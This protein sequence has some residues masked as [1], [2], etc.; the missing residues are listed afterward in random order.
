MNRCAKPSGVKNLASRVSRNIALL[1]S[2]QKPYT[3]G[4]S[5]SAQLGSSSVSEK[6]PRRC[7]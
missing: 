5:S 7:L 6:V 1:V 3:S 2:P 4:T